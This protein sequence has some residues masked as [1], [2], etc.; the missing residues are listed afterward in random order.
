[1]QTQNQMIEIRT[2]RYWNLFDLANLFSVELTSLGAEQYE[3]NLTY[4]IG[5]EVVP[6]K[7]TEKFSMQETE[8]IIRLIMA[9]KNPRPIVKRGWFDYWLASRYN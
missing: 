2:E 5:V 4:L 9:T 8:D 7:I 1:M 3:I 6:V